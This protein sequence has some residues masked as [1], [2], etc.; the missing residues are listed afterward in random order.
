MERHELEELI[1]LKYMYY[2]KTYYPIPYYKFNAV[3]N[4]YQNSN[5]I[6]YRNKQ[7]IHKIHIEPQNT[8]NRQN[9][10]EKKEQCW[11]YHTF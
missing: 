4:L 10:L 11:R 8:P 3:C 1:L 6:F 7:K 5:D 2:W 9:N